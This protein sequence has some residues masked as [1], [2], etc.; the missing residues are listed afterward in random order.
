MSGEPVTMLFTDIAESTR[1]LE[2]LGDRFV[3]LI[4]Q[5][6]RLVRE[7]IAA[8]GGR[9][10]HTAGDS[11][12]AVFGHAE[13]AVRCAEQAQLA[14]AGAEWPGEER[15]RVRMGIHTGAPVVHGSDFAGMD[16]HRAA[17][18]MQ[19]AHG[20]QVL[21]TE[22]TREALGMSTEVRDLGYHRLKDLS[23]PERLFQ[24]LM[25][26][27]QT[28]FPPLRSLNRS[29]LPA[30][31]T[32]LVGRREEFETA[33]ALLSSSEVRLVTLTGPGGVGKT[34]LAIEVATDAISRYRDGVWIVPLAPIGDRALMVSELARVVDVAEVAGEP[35]ER[36]LTAA[37]SE[38]ELLL[39]LDNFEHLLDPCR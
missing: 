15:P 4:G 11:F 13:D 8:H 36:T 2:R 33:R 28:D 31:A 21:L 17:R 1:Q 34:R 38:R 37:V 22:P 35:L 19:V 29:N 20:G 24:L 16:V 12:F 39:V 14:L 5:H 3:E 26:G 25:P 30:P 9:E 27:L 23:G 7:A 18:V 10:V 6:D 32:R